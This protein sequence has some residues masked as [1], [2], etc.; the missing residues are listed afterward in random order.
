MKDYREKELKMYL[1]ACILL[2]IC[3]TKGY[4]TKMETAEK[5][6]AIS[7]IIDT[8]LASSCIYIF[9]YISDALFSSEMK[10][11]LISLFGLIKKPAYT[12]FSNIEKKDVDDR[13]IKTEAIKQYKDIYANMPNNK[14][15]A[16]I[17]QNANWYKIY[18][19]NR[20]VAMIYSS[21]QDYLLCRD[22]FISTIS[23]S[24]LYI[25]SII[26]K[27]FEFNTLYIL[28][29]LAMLLVNLLTTH[30]KAK[31]FVYNVIAYDLTHG[32]NKEKQ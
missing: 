13:F 26:V 16:Y 5:L 28:F 12:V 3:L 17:Y 27:L 10:D 7:A 2:L 25:I 8:T 23:L 30:I 22:M 29:L 18:S 31:R 19:R 21:N 20:D 14:E 15:Q 32:D 6:V 9:V 11:K 4:S 1:L 24:V